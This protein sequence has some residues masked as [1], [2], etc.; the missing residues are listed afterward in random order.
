MMGHKMTVLEPEQYISLYRMSQSASDRSEILNQFRTAYPSLYQQWLIRSNQQRMQN[1]QQRAIALQQKQPQNHEI[2]N[3]LA[4]QQNEPQFMTQAS[5]QIPNLQQLNR[6]TLN[7]NNNNPQQLNRIGIN[8]INNN[9]NNFNSNLQQMQNIMNRASNNQRTRD[10]RSINE[11]VIP[12]NF[13]LRQSMHN[14][15]NTTVN[16]NNNNI[17]NANNYDN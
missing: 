13:M 16:T 8:N 14:P 17:T 7:N 9:I 10:I 4:Y 12:N 11:T 6:E 15:L 5:N 1:N 2:L 3:S